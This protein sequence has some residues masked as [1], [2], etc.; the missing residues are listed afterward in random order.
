MSIKYKWLAGRLELLIQKNI[1]NSIH[2]LPTEKEL[3]TRYH[4]S[5]QTVRMALSLLEQNGLIEK[6]QGSGTYITGRLQNTAENTVGIL[7]SSDQEYIYPGVLSVIKDTLLSGGFKTRIHVTDNC[8]SRERE[9]LEEILKNPVRALIV[10]GCKTALP[11]PNLDLYHRLIKKG[12]VPVFLYNY[13]PAL[14]DVLCIK[15]DNYSGSSMLTEYLA[16]R[17]HTAIG[18]IF[19]SD[20]LQGIERY[21]GFSETMRNLGLKLP[22]SRIGWYGSRELHRLIYEKDTRFLSDIVKDTLRS[23][24]AVICYNDF[25]AYYL[26]DELIRAG[27][28]LPGDM[29]IAAFDNTYLSNSNILTVTTLSHQPH[30]LGLRAAGSVIRKLSGLPA[31]SYEAP[32]ELNLKESTRTEL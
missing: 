28:S 20:D 27:Y 23:C 14:P 21:Q 15:D 2:R 19:K 11:N 30:E 16:S 10:E 29:A 6:R 17:G 13:Y 26:I 4:V 5:R 9:I 22:D 18:G 12:C 8:V 31:S 3:C 25:I 32:W 7:I 1:Q 24:T